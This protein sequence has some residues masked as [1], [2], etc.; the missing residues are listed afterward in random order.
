MIKGRERKREERCRGVESDKH[1]KK[2]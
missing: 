1:S 2:T